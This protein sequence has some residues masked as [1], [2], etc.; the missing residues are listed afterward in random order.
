[1]HNKLVKKFNLFEVFRLEKASAGSNEE[2]FGEL[3]RVHWVFFAQNQESVRLE[4]FLVTGSSPTL[5]Q[6]GGFWEI[7][8]IK[9]QSDG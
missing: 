7:V 4:R 6:P 2:I 9:N 3:Q 5:T 8:E 1:L